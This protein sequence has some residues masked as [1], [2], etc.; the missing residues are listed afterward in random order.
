MREQGL[1]IEGGA[2]PIFMLTGIIPATA[3]VL[4]RAGLAMDVRNN[5]LFATCR[6]PATTG[7]IGTPAAA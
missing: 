6:S 4:E 5:I 1:S 2:D 7:S 3:R